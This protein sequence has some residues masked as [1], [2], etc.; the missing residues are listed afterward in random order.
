MGL[1]DPPTSGS[2]RGSLGAINKLEY[3]STVCS[4][5]YKKDC[6][7][8]ENIQRRAI[9]MLHSIGHLN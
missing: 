5:L 2:T 6:I 1:E 3:T 4:V 7:S 8:I 9:R